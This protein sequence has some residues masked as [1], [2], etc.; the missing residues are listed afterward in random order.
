MRRREAD[1]LVAAEVVHELLNVAQL[2]AEV[3]LALQR[4]AELA[5]GGDRPVRT[6]LGAVFLAQLRQ[7]R[8]DVEVLGDLVLDVVVQHLDDD[9][10]AF[11]QSSQVDLTDRRRRERRRPELGEKLFDGRRAARTR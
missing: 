6:Q 8:H 11:A 5:H 4:A 2:A 3:Q 1:G 7:G 9:L 10:L